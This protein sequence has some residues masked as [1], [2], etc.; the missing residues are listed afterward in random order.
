MLRAC[1]L[2]AP[3][4]ECL[5]IPNDVADVFARP[6]AVDC[7]SHPVLTSGRAK[8][9]W[10]RR[11]RGP[12]SSPSSCLLTSSQGSVM[13]TRG[14]VISEGHEVQKN[15]QA[16]EIWMPGMIAAWSAIEVDG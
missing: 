5:R 1:G 13:C 14:L 6:Q 7:P 12:A 11:S 16:I 15:V 8:H 10:T 2:G 9:L 4:P 3:H